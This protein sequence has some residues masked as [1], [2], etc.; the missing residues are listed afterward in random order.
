MTRWLQPTAGTGIIHINLG[1]DLMQWIRAGNVSAKYMSKI[2]I[3]KRMWE[4]KGERRIKN[5]TSD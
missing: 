5:I 2:I 4:V 1:S 3:I